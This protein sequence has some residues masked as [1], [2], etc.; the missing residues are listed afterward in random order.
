MADL[1][2]MLTAASPHAEIGE[3]RQLYASLI[4]SWEVDATWYEPDG[5]GRQAKGEWRFEWV[6][7][8]RGVQDV[9][10][11]KGAPPDE[12]GTTIRCY[13]ADID[14][15]RVTWMAPAGRE[16]VSLVGRKVGDDIVQ[17]GGALDGSSLERW[18]FSEITQERFRWRGESS[19][20]EGRTWRL[21]QEMRGA[22]LTE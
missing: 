13:D 10:F 8:G 16:F 9:L 2:R 7:G 17:E 11:K 15:W 14:A 20:D 5:S 12:Y 22:R 18:T 3:S 19:R 6:L 21:D 1:Y 4:G